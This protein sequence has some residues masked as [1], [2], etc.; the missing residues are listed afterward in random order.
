VTL[1][2]ADRVYSSPRTLARYVRCHFSGDDPCDYFRQVAAMV[3][4]DAD[5]VVDLGSNVGRSTFDAA[6]KARFVLGLD[7]AHEAIRVASELARGEAVAYDAALEGGATERRTVRRPETSGLVAFA[8]AD[9]AR[10]PVRDG[11]A[12][13]VL[14]LNLIDRLPRP[15]AAIEAAAR[16]LRPGGVL[17]LTDPFTWLEEFTPR[18]EWLGGAAGVRAAIE[19]AGLAIEEERDVTLVIRDHARRVETVTPRLFKAR[20]RGGGSS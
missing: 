18:E 15:R 3:P 7:I 16:L 5:V 2:S 4:D 14:L 19:A 11:V 13:A 1:D 10:P 6:A 9:A 20:R 12:D 8:V 17:V